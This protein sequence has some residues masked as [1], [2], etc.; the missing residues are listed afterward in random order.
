MVDTVSWHGGDASSPE[1]LAEFYYDVPS[2][3]QEIKDV[4]A[5]HGFK[6]EYF[7]EELHWRTPK[8]PHPTEY[9]EYKEV[10]SAKYYG[11]GIVRC[12]GMDLTCGLA[13]ESL[14][15]LPLMVGVVRNLSTVMA[16]AEPESLPVEIQSEATNITSYSFSLPDGDKLIALWTDGVAVENDPGIATTL[17][18]PDISAQRVVDIDVLYGVEQQLITD[19]SDGNLVIRDLLVKDYPIILRL[20]DVTSP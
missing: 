11:R 19:S 5:A 1:H 16:G 9:D 20:T 6:G 14:E 8:D 12:L 17:I 2:L 3:V 18:V 10:A 7:L 4:A 15:E 13:L